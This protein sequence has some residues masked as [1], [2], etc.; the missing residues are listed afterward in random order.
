LPI[1]FAVLRAYA[2]RTFTKTY[3]LQPHGALVW[4]TTPDVHA[5]VWVEHGAPG[6]GVEFHGYKLETLPTLKDMARWLIDNTTRTDYAIGMGR[7]REGAALQVD[8]DWQDVIGRKQVNYDDHA[9]TLLVLDLDT[10]QGDL[11]DDPQE[12]I[13]EAVYSVTE[14]DGAAFV[15]SWSPSAGIKSGL[16]CRVFIELDAPITLAQ[17]KVAGDRINKRGGVQFDTS[18]Y[19]QQAFVAVSAPVLYAN[20]VAGHQP[21]TRPVPAPVAWF[22]DG[23]LVTLGNIQAAVTVGVPLTALAAL[24][25]AAAQGLSAGPTANDWLAAMGPGNTSN[26]LHKALCREA[27]ASPEDQQAQRLSSFLARA[28]QRILEFSTDAQDFERRCKEHLNIRVLQKQWDDARRRKHTLAPTYRAMPNNFGTNGVSA[29]A[30][31]H[32]APTFPSGNIQAQSA[33]TDPNSSRAVTGVTPLLPPR[34]QMALEVEQAA[35]RIFAGSAEQCLVTAPPGAGKTYALRKILTAGV[36]SSRRTL[37][38]V[39]TH[40]LAEQLHQDLQAHALTLAPLGLHHGVDLV[41]AVRHHKGRKP[42]CTNAK[43][44]AMATRAEQVGISAKKHACATCPD[45]GTCPWIKQFEDDAPGVI[46]KVH[47]AITNASAQK[48][49]WHELA[50]IDESLL[51][52]II[53]EPRPDLKLSELPKE[54]FSVLLRDHRE[55]LGA[56]LYS[57]LPV[58]Y[59]LR[60]TVPIAWTCDELAVRLD[61]ESA[62]RDTLTKNLVA[63]TEKKFA[64]QLALIEKSRAVTAIYENMLD[65][66]ARTDTTQTQAKG[67]RV[68]RDKRGAWV[69]CR[70]R[71]FLPPSILAKGAIHLDGTAKL[72]GMLAVWQTTI[73]PNGAPIHTTRVESAPVPEHTRITQITDSSFAKAALLDKPDAA[74][75]EQL[76]L[77]EKTAAAH[78]LDNALGEEG[79]ALRQTASIA[80]HTLT[81]RKRG[82]KRRAD[83]RIFSVWLVLTDMAHRLRKRA[84]ANP[85]RSNEVL[86]VA[87]KEIIDDLIALGLPS[88]VR[89]AHFGALRGLNAYKDVAGAVIVGRPALSNDELEL[90]TEAIFVRHPD[91]DNVHHADKWGKVPGAVQLADMQWATVECDG[92]PDLYCRAVQALISQAEVVQGLARVRPYTRTAMTPCEV[93]Y[94]G[95]YSPG[96]PVERICSTTDVRPNEAAV[97]MRAGGL[98][99]NADAN[100]AW[101]DQMFMASDSKSQGGRGQ[102]QTQR[103]FMQQAILAWWS[104]RNRAQKGALPMQHAIS[105][106][107]ENIV[108]NQQIPDSSSRNECA[109]YPYI[110]SKGS[111]GQFDQTEYGKTAHSSQHVQLEH[112]YRFWKLSVLGNQ[113]MQ[114]AG[115]RGGEYGAY[116][117]TIFVV[118]ESGLEVAD[119]AARLQLCVKHAHELSDTE[120]ETECARMLRAII[121]HAVGEMPALAP[122]AAGAD[123]IEFLETWLGWGEVFGR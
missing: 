56:V 80:A 51:G 54:T 41:A 12:K 18:I 93:V 85:G 97:A 121:E 55:Q 60:A 92:H 59:N 4:S 107:H 40:A 6:K 17:M 67:V 101:H 2:Q 37:I 38:L 116:A 45:A 117:R 78:W 108:M 23:D 81:S 84:G 62:H 26:N 96:I 76:A 87:Q 123:P 114:R 65:S 14:F 90:L 63:A 21:L 42:L 30:T 111:A 19:S 7:L 28:R 64:R 75:D 77:A 20:T 110:V 27:F 1:Q 25:E 102:W 113:Y 98:T 100:R 13:R 103:W 24:A 88:N 34:E 10:V 48:E 109:V 8:G 95:Q 9:S 68:Y 104:R 72:D 36:L 66:L 33:P 112:E 122:Y 106:K 69:T 94:F 49:D 53:E 46:I 22:C 91:R 74:L 35:A 73:S 115:R 39:P 15:A 5:G 118:A 99:S 61:A 82:R 89:A 58:G 16:R 52:S 11:W 119:L 32:N 3:E 83:S 50:I 70:R 57:A 105:Q 71:Q 29:Q 120:I 31:L 86:L 79:K 47:S 43:H 44:G